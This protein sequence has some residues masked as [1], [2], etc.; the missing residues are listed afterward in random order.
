MT[1]E[2]WPTDHLTD[3]ERRLARLWNTIPDDDGELV[4]LTEERAAILFAVED[5]LNKAQLATGHLDP[6]APLAPLLRLRDLVGWVKTDLQKGLL[7]ADLIGTPGSYA[8]QIEEAIE[9]LWAAWE[10]VER[11][12]GRPPLTHNEAVADVA[13]R[14]SWDQPLGPDA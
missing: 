9:A 4:E 14:L 2:M 10:P 7:Q 12:N 11:Q 5:A 3:A 8:A 6:K 13:D 1:D